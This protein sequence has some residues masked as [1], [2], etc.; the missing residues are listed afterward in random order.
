MNA[1][2]GTAPRTQGPFFS[3][4]ILMAEGQ[5]PLSSA[6]DEAPWKWTS[7]C[8]FHPHCRSLFFFLSPLFFFFFLQKW[9][10]FSLH[11][12]TYFTKLAHTNNLFPTSS[13]AITYRTNQ[14]NLFLFFNSLKSFSIKALLRSVGEDSWKCSSFPP[15][16]SVWFK[17]NNGEAFLLPPRLTC[18]KVICLQRWT[19]GNTHSHSAKMH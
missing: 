3:I 2:E 6:S 10:T 4:C 17:R 12:I 1:L 16:D 8:S 7:V 11:I 19:S 9:L 15:M 5:W 13:P 14:P 18:I